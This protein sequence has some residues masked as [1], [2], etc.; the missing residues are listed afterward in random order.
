MKSILLIA[1]VSLMFGGVAFA[2]PA[3]KKAVG[4]DCKECHIPGKFKEK[5]DKPM[6]VAAEKM[7]AKY[8][9]KNKTCEECHQGKRKPDDKEKK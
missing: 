4:I 2:K 1:G 8:K 5:T 3:F 6:F 9:G 7:I